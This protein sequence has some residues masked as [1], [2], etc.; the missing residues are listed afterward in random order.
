MPCFV[1]LSSSFSR[2]PLCAHHAVDVPHRR[3]RTINSIKTAARLAQP[4]KRP[5]AEAE[6]AAAAHSTDSG[7]TATTT[8]VAREGRRLPVRPRPLA[9]ASTMPHML[10]GSALQATSGSGGGSGAG[11]GNGADKRGSLRKMSTPVPLGLDTSAA[12]S[13]ASASET[14]TVSVSAPAP[15]PAVSSSLSSSPLRAKVHRKPA[16]TAIIELGIPLP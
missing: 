9:R 3:K 11:G 2:P 15:A 16:A 5:V 14:E 12:A 13:P 6:P 8:A 7:A 1:S 4:A 10:A